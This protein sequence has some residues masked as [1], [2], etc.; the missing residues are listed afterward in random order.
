MHFLLR[1]LPL[2]TFML[3]C[4]ADLPVPP[5]VLDPQTRSESWNVIRLAT[6]N[7]SRLLKEQRVEEVA[8]QISLCSPALRMLART[9]ASEQERSL[10]GTQTSLAF[11][12]INDI[13]R[14]GMAR[15]QPSVEVSFARLQEVLETL[16]TAFVAED[17]NAEIYTCPQHPETLLTK[18][19]TC[20]F[21]DAPLRVRRIPYT[22][23]YATPETAQTRLEIQADAKLVP[24]APM[25]FTASVQTSAGKPTALSDFVL[26][27]GAS[28]RLW[29]I[30]PTLTDF[31][32]FTPDAMKSNSSFTPA[33][34]GPYRVWAE[35]VPVETAIPEHPFADLGSAFQVVDRSRHD[36]LDALEVT[37]G[38]LRFQ[39]TF[40]SG[41]G[42]A[43]IAKQVSLMRL[44][45][46]DTT[47]QPI[48]RLEP[49]MNAFAHLTGIYADGKTVLRLHPVGG[50]VLREDLRGGPMLAFK[51]Y[52][53]QS[54]FVRFFCQV[55]VDGKIITVP[56]G[57]N[58]AP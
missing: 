12:L 22:E 13:A 8:Q 21:C 54:G 1:W 35:V 7:V 46:T 49:L 14:D 24:G 40:T 2:I 57:V 50:D 28:V 52:P 18:P 58:I 5:Q 20:R 33:T 26:N 37:T 3:S 42:G 48:T 55:K 9:G 45:I 47:G 16:Q 10:I 19:G 30:D 31:H 6:A 36:F 25:T 17:I 39:L 32:L 4:R 53:P 23:L 44:N 41:N 43:P 11:R 15:L 51:I 29:L 34:A 38:G 56:L 27:H